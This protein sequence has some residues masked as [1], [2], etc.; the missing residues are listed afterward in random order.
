VKV[1]TSV[2][3]PLFAGLEDEWAEHAQWD[4][5]YQ[6]KN[7]SALSV[8]AVYRDWVDG[9]W[10]RGRAFQEEE[11][12]N[13]VECSIRHPDVTGEM[14]RVIAECFL[15]AVD[16]AKEE[17][18]SPEVKSWVRT[19]VP[20]RFGSFALAHRNCPVD[21]LSRAARSG[22]WRLAVAAA[23]NPVCPEEDA[24]YASL[25]FSSRPSFVS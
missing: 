10:G 12:R 19:R 20:H 23:G 4:S 1:T 25:M 11:L 22:V 16:A 3:A 6:Y 7:L 17:G 14:L 24:V 15:D 8:L 21:V 5:T 13:L 18:C 9:W 2:V